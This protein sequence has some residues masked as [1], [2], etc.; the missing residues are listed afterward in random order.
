M[1]ILESVRY[2]S[3]CS[4]LGTC[5]NSIFRVVIRLGKERRCAEEIRKVAL[6][7]KGWGSHALCQ[8]QTGSRRKI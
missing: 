1:G 7:L 2:S 6:E 3:I 5:I 8:T 4:A